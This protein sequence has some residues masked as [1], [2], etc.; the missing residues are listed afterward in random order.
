MCDVYINNF[1]SF[2]IFLCAK[3]EKYLMWN[4]FLNELIKEG[5]DCI[6]ESW[7]GRS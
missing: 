5:V 2:F 1:F 4:H 6:G 7:V 3:L